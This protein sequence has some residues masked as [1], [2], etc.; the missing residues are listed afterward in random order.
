MPTFGAGDTP[1]LA[2]QADL[3][4]PTPTFRL[5][6]TRRLTVECEVGGPLRVF[7]VSFCWPGCCTLLLAGRG[8]FGAGR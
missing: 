7:R 4:R 2:A 6:A 8:R 3:M 1:R 5:S